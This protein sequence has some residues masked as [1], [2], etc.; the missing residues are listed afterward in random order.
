MLVL[1]E[2]LLEERRGERVDGVELLARL[3][4]AIGLRR[5]PGGLP[6]LFFDRD[7]GALGERTHR[8][9]ERVALVL[10]EEVDGAARLLASEA[11]EEPAI[12]VHVEAR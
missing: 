8:L 12:G 11:V 1:A 10:H 4:L 6:A 2:L 9:G 5:L 3:A 7:A